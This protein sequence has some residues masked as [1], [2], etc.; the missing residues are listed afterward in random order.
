MPRTAQVKST[1]FSNRRYA[2]PFFVPTP[3]ADRQPVDGARRMTDWSK[4]QLG[5][6]PPIRN[7]GVMNLMDIIGSEGT[8][9]IEQVGQIRFHTLGDS[10][11]NHA[12]EA[13]QISDEMATDFRVD[14]GG[15]NPA[16]FPP[17]R[18][19]LWS[20]QARPLW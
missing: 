10:G 12:E 18:R 3:I 15:L 9:E 20:W 7:N 5:P 16:F 19:N 8:A 14:A 1:K 17:R 13:E 11:V 6:L 2:H 4:K